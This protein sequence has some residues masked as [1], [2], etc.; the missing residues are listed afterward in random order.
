MEQNG[1]EPWERD[2]LSCARPE[3]HAGSVTGQQDEVGGAGTRRT[4][5]V[6]RYCWMREVTR[7]YGECT[8]LSCVADPPE[9][10]SAPINI[11]LNF[12]ADLQAI[13]ALNNC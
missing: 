10:Q 4:I 12:P 5:P 11:V 1:L 13:A 9:N 6:S 8:A 2:F 3:N 7:S